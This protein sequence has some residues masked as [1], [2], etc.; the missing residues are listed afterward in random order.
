MKRLIWITFISVCFAQDVK[1]PAVDADSFY[2]CGNAHATASMPNSHDA[3]G[4]STN[5]VIG[6]SG[7]ITCD[8]F[9]CNSNTLNYGRVFTN[10]PS[11]SS[12]YTALTLNINS[13]A[14]GWQNSNG[15]GGNVF[16]FY[17]LDNGVTFTSV[18][19]DSIGT[20]W[21][22]T[23]DTITLS[24]SQDLTKLQVAVCAVGNGTGTVPHPSV[25]TAGADSITI[26]DIWT[27]GTTSGQGPG[28]GSSAGKRHNAVI[29]N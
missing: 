8:Q 12:T 16:V 21:A 6:G 1:R 7:S 3:A 14:F 25:P 20:G 11:A 19:N 4:L 17:S 28:T 2:N 26:W 13:S 27:L 10:W 9:T 22:Q 15:I 5:S 23:T 29:V 18:R 24:P